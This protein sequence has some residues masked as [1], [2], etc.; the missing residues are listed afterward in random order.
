[1]LRGEEAVR[2]EGEGRRDEENLMKLAQT[3]V[4]I[5]AVAISF[6]S[7]AARAP[8]PAG[9][10]PNRP[11]RLIMPNAPGSSTDTMGRIAAAKQSRSV[12]V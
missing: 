2:D 5:A 6:P 11:I 10:Y 8:D 1:M 7:L 3:V 9:D 12:R 4:L